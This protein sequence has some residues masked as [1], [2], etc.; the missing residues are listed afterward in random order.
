MKCVIC[1][2]GPA[3]GVT[4][5][6]INRKG[7]EGFWACKKHKDQTDAPPVDPDVQF[8][9]DIVEKRRG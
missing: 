4:L 5:Y 1:Q 3:Q 7:V 8:I 9:V 2:K 6:R